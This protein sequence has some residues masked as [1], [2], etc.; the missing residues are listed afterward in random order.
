MSAEGT[1]SQ[2]E[3]CW[4]VHVHFVSFAF[5][6]SLSKKKKECTVSLTL[7]SNRATTC[8]KKLKIL[9]FT[10]VLCTRCPAEKLNCVI[11]SFLFRFYSN[12]TAAVWDRGGKIFDFFKLK[13]V[14]LEYS[15]YSSWDSPVFFDQS[16]KCIVHHVM[17]W[18]ALN[19]TTDWLTTL[20][21]ET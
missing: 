21:R 15:V 10:S 8:A 6:G 14:S 11:Q 5:R 20:C 19:F 9:L 16:V 3:T 13:N 7:D 4:R 12:M 1:S 2:A 17:L 18:V